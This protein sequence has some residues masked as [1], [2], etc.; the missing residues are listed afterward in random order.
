MTSSMQSSAQIMINN[1]TY[2]ATQQTWTMILQSSGHPI[3]ATAK[4]F[5]PHSATAIEHSSL[6]TMANR[7]SAY[8]RGHQWLMKNVNK[9]ERRQLNALQ[10][11]D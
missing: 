7:E 5:D 8:H 1:D 10:W 6:H 3:L 11:L 4:L 9:D 2:R